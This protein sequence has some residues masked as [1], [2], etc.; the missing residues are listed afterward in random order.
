MG[1]AGDD[2]FSIVVIGTLGIFFW[3]GVWTVMDTHFLIWN[4]II[5]AVASVGVGYFI[6]VVVL[7]FQRTASAIAAQLYTSQRILLKH[8]F[9]DLFILLASVGA[10][11]AWRGIWILLNELF[12]TDNYELSN[13]VCHVV[14]LLGLIIVYNSN[15][16]LSRGV[17]I[18]GDTPSGQGGCMFTIDYLAILYKVNSMNS[19]SEKHVPQPI[20]SNITEANP[21]INEDNTIPFIDDEKLSNSYKEGLC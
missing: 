1:L 19:S 3:R 15:T 16:L 6:T 2:V 12:L 11:F 13:W 20:P 14:G 5:S 10:I 8:V 21:I 17:Y 9:D 18:D 7:A 4:Q